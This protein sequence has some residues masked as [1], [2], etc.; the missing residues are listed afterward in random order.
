MVFKFV[1]IYEFKIKYNTCHPE[2]VSGSIILYK[3][4]SWNEFSL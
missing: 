2:L 3:T 1:L 4:R